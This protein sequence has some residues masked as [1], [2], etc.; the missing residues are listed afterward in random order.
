MRWMSDA[1]LQGVILTQQGRDTP[2]SR[3]H[4]G[5]A[6]GKAR[7]APRQGQGRPQD[8]EGRL[9]PLGPRA[10]GRGPQ[11]LRDDAMAGKLTGRR[12]RSNEQ[13]GAATSFGC[14]AP[15]RPPGRR[16]LKQPGHVPGCAPI[17]IDE[18][19][20]RT[21]LQLE[22]AAWIGQGAELDK[23]A[24]KQWQECKLVSRDVLVRTSPDA[25]L[26][27]L[28][29]LKGRRTRQGNAKD[30]VV[31]SATPCGRPIRR[32]LGLHERGRVRCA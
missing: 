27:A 30:E 31:V 15:G 11:E 19:H 10:M 25:P 3:S 8:R 23:V 1:R 24:P 9:F 20:I 13:M 2:G 21:W 7:D 32:S 29:H 26:G 6:L 4:V 14:W 22:R 17:E 12:K 28:L 5:T 18:I 16:Q